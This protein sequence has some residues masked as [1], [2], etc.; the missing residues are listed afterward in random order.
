MPMS[1]NVPVL[2]IDAALGGGAAERVF[3]AVGSL[4]GNLRY[5]HGLLI[6]F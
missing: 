6:R 4:K 2:P 5:R 1:E 3:V